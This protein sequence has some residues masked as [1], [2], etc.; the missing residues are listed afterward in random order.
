M[1][2]KTFQRNKV[3]SWSL[4]FETAQENGSWFIYYYDSNGI[5][6]FKVQIDEATKTMAKGLITSIK[7]WMDSSDTWSGDVVETWKK[8][9]VTHPASNIEEWVKQ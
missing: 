9:N 1:V 8:Q 2:S 4:N 6:M 7:A 5:D 3:F